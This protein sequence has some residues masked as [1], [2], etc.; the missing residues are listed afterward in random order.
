MNRITSGLMALRRAL[1]R[2]RTAEP[3]VRKMLDLATCHLPSSEFGDEMNSWDGVIAFPN[4]EY[5]WILWVPDDPEE[6]SADYDG[7]VPAEVLRI[8]LYAR[9]HGCDYVMFDRDGPVDGNL[10]TWDW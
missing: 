1:R 9:Q 10:P 7:E 3:A 6:E 8:Q 4:R 5:G 2:Q